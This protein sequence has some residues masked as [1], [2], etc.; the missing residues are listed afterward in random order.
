MYYELKQQLKEHPFWVEG[1]VELDINVEEAK[2]EFIL[3]CE[4]LLGSWNYN[5]E[6]INRD[7]RI[8]F[9]ATEKIDNEDNQN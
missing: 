9:K 1:V 6:I 5:L 2:K 3:E 4:A 8:V 7:N